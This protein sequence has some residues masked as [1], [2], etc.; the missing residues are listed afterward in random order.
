M[1]KLDINWAMF[2]RKLWTSGIKVALNDEI[3]KKTSNHFDDMAIQLCDT[4]VDRLL[5]INHD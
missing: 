5:P 3:V 2:G 4:L 1:E